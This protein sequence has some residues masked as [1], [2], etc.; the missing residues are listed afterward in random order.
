VAPTQKLSASFLA[1]VEP[2][3]VDAIRQRSVIHHHRSGD[4]LCET[5]G[6][7][8]GILLSGMA[9]V[10]L[11]TPGGRQVTLR[12]AHAGGSIGIGALLGEGAV[13]AQAV[14][15]CTVMRLDHQQVIRLAGEHA[16]LALA[17]AKELSTRLIETYRE[18][19]IREQGSLRQRLARQLLHFA[20]EAEDP[21]RPL[22]L[23]MSHEDLAEAV[24]SAREVVTRHLS[25]FQAE[26][27]LALDRGQ[28]TLTDPVRLH[29][30]AGQT[31]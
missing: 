8:T 4:I 23:P 28:I 10:F 30:T 21:E 24:G 26:Q 13:S 6:H 15:D 11:R 22:V 25:R 20:G 3:V 1:D 27:M 18:M 31:D 7:W 29:Q 19:V 5:N 9:R 12:H 14:T 16:S 17:I 2:S